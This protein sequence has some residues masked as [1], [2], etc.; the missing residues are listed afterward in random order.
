[1]TETRRAELRLVASSNGS[2]DDSALAERIEALVQQPAAVREL[3]ALDLHQLTRRA[4]LIESL[5][6]LELARGEQVRDTVDLQVWRDPVEV[7]VAKLLEWLSALSQLT[8]GAFHRHY[9]A[10]DVELIALLLLRTT[11]VSLLQDEEPPPDPEGRPLATPDGWFALDLLGENET[12]NDQIAA[13]VAA[14]YRD[15]PDDARRLL[16]NL[17]AELPTE[18][19]ETAARWRRRRLEDL[20][21]GDVNEALRIYTYLD[22]ARVSAD[23]DGTA[24]Q[25]LRAD[26]EPAGAGELATAIPPDPDCFWNRGLAEV[27][28]A[29]ERRRI[30]GALVVLSNV[31]LAADRVDPADLER[32]TRTLEHLRGRLSLGLERLCKGVPA[33]APAALR[34]VAL[35]R[36]ARLGHS[37]VLQQ[38]RRLPPLLRDG[39]LRHGNDPV[40]LLDTPWHAAIGAL[41]ATPPMYAPPHALRR[42]FAAAADLDAVAGSIDEVA[43]ALALVPPSA[44][45]VPLPESATLASLFCTAVASEA[46]GRDGALDRAGL[47]TLRD[48]LAGTARPDAEFFAAA[49]RVATLR[50][51]APPAAPT[52]ALIEGWLMALHRELSALSDV[53]IDPRFVKRVWVATDLR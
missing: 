24:D 48:R 23:H 26:P 49:D 21:F 43:L 50:L 10:L 37:L 9:R 27:V 33:A 30:G 17:I 47:H 6:L 13:L 35:L 29:A 39:Q 25:P 36:V 8:E 4:G 40:G 3:A 44:R 28:D 53:A 41:L 22:P 5:P 11:R 1:M 20:G 38:Q 46:L 18:L 2:T 7:D 34:Q 14:L 51:K 19:E 16:H 12:Q 42:P 45:P 52:L 31:N 32:V 15:G